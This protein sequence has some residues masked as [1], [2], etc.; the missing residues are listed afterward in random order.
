MIAV[1]I[2][3]VAEKQQVTAIVPLA[4]RAVVKHFHEIPYGRDI[5]RSG[6][7]FIKYL[8]AGGPPPHPGRHF[9]SG[10]VP[11]SRLPPGRIPV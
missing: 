2:G 4:S 11:V 7:K 6:R 3:S 5:G 8:L 9:L 1:V 10:A